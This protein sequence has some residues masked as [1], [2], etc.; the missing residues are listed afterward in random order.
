[1]LNTTQGHTV[2]S[3]LQAPFTGTYTSQSAQIYGILKDMNETWT[4][5]LDQIRSYPDGLEQRTF[6]ESAVL[7][8]ELKTELK[9]LQSSLER[10]K[11]ATAANQKEL[12]ILKRELQ[13]EKNELNDMTKFLDEL[14]P[15]CEKKEESYNTRKMLRANEGAAV[16]E[17]I[18][19]LSSDAVFETFSQSKST[20]DTAYRPTFLQIHQH[21]GGANV[22]I[23]S[24]RMEAAKLL[25]E[26]M[27]SSQSKRLPMVVSALQA[28]NPFNTVLSQIDEMLVL[29]DEEEKA[30]Q[31]GYDQCNR[32]I[33]DLEKDEHEMESDLHVKER[34]VQETKRDSAST[35]NKIEKTESLLQTERQKMVEMTATRTAENL[36]YQTDVKNLQD[37]E[38]ILTKAVKV[39]KTY[40]DDLEAQI[41][42]GQAG[43]AGLFRRALT[44]KPHMPLPSS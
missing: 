31:K 15:I 22:G 10:E 35:A 9:L 39:L 40:Y 1:M 29:I 30:D 28:E 38:I 18:S 23:S 5:K 32:D 44:R 2:K 25:K 6:V 14:V 17:A 7:R 8:Q 24:G 43:A 19:I 13:A 36:D 21:G 16:A 34:Q 3:F 4:Q 20:Q 12:A 33:D 37:A 42:L 11:G 27:K 41:R 26:A